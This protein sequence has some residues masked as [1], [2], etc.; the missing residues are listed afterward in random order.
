MRAKKSMVKAL[1]YIKGV[2][3]MA[4]LPGMYSYD[5][6]NPMHHNPMHAHNPYAAGQPIGRV[7][8]AGG[9][10][11]GGGH[12]LSGIIRFFFMEAE[13]LGSNDLEEFMKHETNT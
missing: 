3:R 7:D 9:G 1:L 13:H 4:D 10:A 8:H 6:H 11:A 2:R 12:L 5:A